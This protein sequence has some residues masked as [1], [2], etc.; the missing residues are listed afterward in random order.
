MIEDLI[1]SAEVVNDVAMVSN[2]KITLSAQPSGGIIGGV[3]QVRM[4]ND[5]VYD[6]VDVLLSGTTVTLN[7]STP[8]EYDGKVAIVSFLKVS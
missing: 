3:C 8:G 7:V 5:E 6:E 2:D 1:S 4:G